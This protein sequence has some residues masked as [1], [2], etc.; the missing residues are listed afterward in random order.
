MLKQEFLTYI[1][2][3]YVPCYTVRALRKGRYITAVI[4]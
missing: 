1:E 2:V 4:F 3:S